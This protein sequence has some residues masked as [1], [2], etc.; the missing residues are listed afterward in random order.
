MRLP[1]GASCEVLFGGD[2]FLHGFIST[3]FEAASADHVGLVARARQF[4]SFILFIGRIASVDLFDPKHAIIIQNKVR[5]SRVLR[6]HKCA[7][8]TTSSTQT[9]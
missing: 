1:L 4:S 3:K 7:H 9:L 5:S 8:R 6:R 2:R